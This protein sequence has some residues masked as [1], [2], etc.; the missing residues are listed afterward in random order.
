MLDSKRQPLLGLYAAL[1]HLYPSS[2][3]RQFG[4][5]MLAAFSD[6]LDDRGPLLASSI[7][8]REFLFTLFRE[9]LDDPASLAHFIRVLLC[10]LP[11]VAIYTAVLAHIRNFEGFALFTSWLICILASFWQTRSRGR[12]CLVRT[13]L[14]SVVGMLLPLA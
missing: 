8:L 5:Q 7:I 6:L 1:L 2:F 4:Q 14:A 12:D 11:P 9:H 13:M 3:R 10:P